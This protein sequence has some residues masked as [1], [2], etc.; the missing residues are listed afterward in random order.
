MT[1]Y[2]AR[3]EAAIVWLGPHYVFDRARYIQRI[4]AEQQ[5]EMHKADVAATFAR[6]RER[7]QKPLVVVA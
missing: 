6:I 5:I 2:S 7:E 4:P 3:L 1:D